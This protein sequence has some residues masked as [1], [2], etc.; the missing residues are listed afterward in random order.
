MVTIPEAAEDNM[1]DM[2]TFRTAI[3]IENV[4]RRGELRTLADVLVDTGSEYTW[5]PRE[6]LVALGIA[7]ERTQRF[8]VADGRAIER[9]MGFAIVHAAGTFA[10]DFVVFAEPGD[11][12]L[13]G[14]RSLEGLNLRIDPMRKILIDAGPIV[15]AAA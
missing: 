1:T 14:A 6:V 7:P 2:G 15:T 3:S 13:L 10:P 11:L 12:V 8:V 4:A 9:E 5:A